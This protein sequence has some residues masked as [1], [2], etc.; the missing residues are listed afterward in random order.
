MRRLLLL[1]VLATPLAAQP[2]H[3]DVSWPNAAAHETE[4][5]ATFAGVGE[6]PLHVVMSRTSPGR[7]A[8]H[9]FAK[10]VFDVSATDGAGRPVGVQRVTPYEWVVWG[11]DGTV[12]FDYTLYANRADGT[13][14]G[15]DTTHAHYN[16]PAAFVWARG[17]EG[18][19]HQATFHP[20]PGWRVATQLVATDEP[21]TFEAPDLA[22]FMDSPTEVS[23]FDLYEWEQ[24]GQTYRMA[25]HHLGTDAEAEAYVEMAQDVIAEQAAVFGAYPEFDHGT[26]TFLADYLPWVAGDGMEHRNS[27]ILTSTGSLA[28]PLGVLGTLA[29][30]HFHAWNMERLRDAA[31]EPFDFEAANMS[32]NLWFGEGF[33][34][35]Y[36]GLTRVR[37]GAMTLEEYAA[38]MTGQLNYVLLSPARATR[39]PAEMSR[40][41]TFVDAASAIDEVAYNNTFVSYYTWGEILG[42]GLDLALR[43]RYDATLDDV[44][45]TMWE[46]FGEHQHATTPAR[47]YTAA[48]IERVLGEV[49][50]APAWA[51]DVFDRTIEAGGVLDYAALVEPAGLVLRPARPDHGWFGPVALQAGD[52]GSLVI[53]PVRPGTPAYAAGLSSGDRLLTVDGVAATSTQAVTDV[54]AD[55]APGDEVTVTYEQRGQIKT[56]RVALLADPA[57]ELVTFEAAGRPVTDEIRAF[58]EAW[59]GSKAG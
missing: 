21:N 32:E 37:A 14:A 41:A 46:E 43:Q 30:E 16:M 2:V 25:L 13:Y 33:T 24:G 49:S 45:R 48:D 6:A 38:D 42:F 47:P 9:E 53:A 35:Y 23:A 5:T 22:Y 51:A 17:L 28:E 40:M 4:F 26:Y 55:A 59:L 58:R 29:H 56:A 7:Y 20:L 10:N 8:L 39:G 15:V 1:L 19:P 34:S 36:D 57:L 44:M 12:R 18:R 52:G 27:T 54:L 11:H 3:Y 31:L 50:G